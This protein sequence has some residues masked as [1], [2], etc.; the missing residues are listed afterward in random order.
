MIRGRSKAGHADLPYLSFP[1]RS[2][3]GDGPRRLPLR[4]IISVLDPDETEQADLRAAQLIGG[5]IAGST[6][7]LTADFALDREGTSIGR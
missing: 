1:A 3:S 2:V 6:S 7:E 5:L 4:I